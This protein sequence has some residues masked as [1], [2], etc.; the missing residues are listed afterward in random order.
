MNK[1]SVIQLRVISCI[2]DGPK[3]F[4]EI[5]SFCKLESNKL[6]Y[7]IKKLKDDLYIQKDD[8]LYCLTP[9][10]KNVYPYITLFNG[11]SAPVFSVVSVVLKYKGQYYLKRKEAEPDKGSLIFFGCKAQPE[12]TFLE[13]A[14]KVLKEQ[15]G[16][17]SNLSLKVIHEY[18]A[19]NQ[20]WVIF[21]FFGETNTKPKGVGLT[22]SESKRAHLFGDNVEVLECLSKN[23]PLR[24]ITTV[25]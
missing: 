13:T 15:A 2:H 11:E 20:H 17:E 18:L 25:K 1:L 19:P 24:F 3:T 22:L 12:K 16:V 10:T 8:G 7:H 4:N 5:K 14:A 6:S 23:K 9:Y 21:T